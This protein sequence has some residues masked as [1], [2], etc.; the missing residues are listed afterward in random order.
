MASA[1]LE[2]IL[3]LTRGSPA[4][5]S[6]AAPARSAVTSSTCGDADAVAGP[7]CGG[8]RRCL[9]ER[10][11]RVYEKRHIY[12]LQAAFSEK[13]ELQDNKTRLEPIFDTRIASDR[14]KRW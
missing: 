11:R 2:I 12:A 5:D 3:I 13:Q 10:R 4:L 1:S 9:R 14:I 7:P 8:C 6:Q